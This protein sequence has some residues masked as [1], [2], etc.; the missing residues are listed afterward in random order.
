MWTL[1]V[2]ALA[3]TPCGGIRKGGLVQRALVCALAALA[4][5]YVT[6]L[7][8]DYFYEWFWN[9]DSWEAYQVISRRSREYGV[10]QV[11]SRSPMTSSL[12]FYRLA[13]RN[14]QL[15]EFKDPLPVPNGKMPTDKI[16]YALYESIDGDFIRDQQL[17]I[18]YRGRIYS[19]FVIALRPHLTPRRPDGVLNPSES[20]GR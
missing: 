12:E 11:P 5:F 4:I 7:R 20:A 16:L 6:C 1:I 2:A 15:M 9:A 14:D 10:A 19:D 8:K 17:Q 13:S 18:I 3:A